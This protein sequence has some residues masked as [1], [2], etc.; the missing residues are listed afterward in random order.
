M[1]RDTIES[2]ISIVDLPDTIYPAKNYFEILEFCVFID[3]SDM[4][5]ILYINIWYASPELKWITNIF[6]RS[7]IVPRALLEFKKNLKRIP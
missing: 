3:G 7:L 2:E 4:G 6:R 5:V 1:E